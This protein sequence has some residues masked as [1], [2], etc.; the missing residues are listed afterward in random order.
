M[1]NG[2][3]FGPPPPNRRQDNIFETKDRYF[4]R[5]LLGLWI[6]TF[7]IYTPNAYLT[8]G[9]YASA[10]AQAAIAPI[11]AANGINTDGTAVLKRVS[12]IDSLT[13]QGFLQQFV[14]PRAQLVATA[15]PRY[16]V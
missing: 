11:A 7:T 9:Q 2:I 12:E 1:P 13:V 3:G 16:V 4:C 15:A 10:A 8:N 6:L 14:M 5:D